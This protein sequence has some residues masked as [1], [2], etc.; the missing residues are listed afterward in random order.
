MDK[1]SKNAKIRRAREASI[2]VT[3]SWRSNNDLRCR[4]LF[5]DSN[6]HE[7]ISHFLDVARLV[8]NL[9]GDRIGPFVVKPTAS[10]TIGDIAHLPDEV[11]AVLIF[12]IDQVLA[13]QR[14]S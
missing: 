1:F 7:I 10:G 12:E 5:I 3:F 2:E 14:G 4:L 9:V 8:F 13:D 11:L 6:A